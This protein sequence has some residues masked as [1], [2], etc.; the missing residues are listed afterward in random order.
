MHESWQPSILQVFVLS[1][2][3]EVIWWNCF[4]IAIYK[5]EKQNIAMSVFSQYSSAYYISVNFHFI[6]KHIPIIV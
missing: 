2:L 4:H 6:M 1:Q 5:A 3:I